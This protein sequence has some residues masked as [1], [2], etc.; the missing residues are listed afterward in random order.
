MGAA[1]NELQANV[2]GV[3][4]AIAPVGEERERGRLPL[5]EGRLQP[6]QLHLVRA[7]SLRAGHPQEVNQR[8]VDHLEE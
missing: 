1:P 2:V 8:L 5:R 6:L 3:G 4:R 7:R